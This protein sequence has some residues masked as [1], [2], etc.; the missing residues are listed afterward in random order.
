VERADLV[1]P[2]QAT[3]VGERRVDRAAEPLFQA[4][5]DGAREGG[6]DF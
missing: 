1:E 5:A 4:L 6:L 2:E 3:E